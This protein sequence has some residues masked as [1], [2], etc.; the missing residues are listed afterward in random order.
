MCF[1]HCER[2][3]ILLQPGRG[4]DYSAAG[5]YSADRT[6]LVAILATAKIQSMRFVILIV[7]KHFD[8]DERGSEHIC[9][10]CQR[11]HAIEESNLELLSLIH[12]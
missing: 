4:R 12:I 10:G 5:D 7:W 3:H 2:A 1:P 11:Y 8:V 6:I 9:S